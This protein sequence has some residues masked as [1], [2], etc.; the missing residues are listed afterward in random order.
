MK[1]VGNKDNDEE[2]SDRGSEA[3]DV[4]GGGGDVGGGAAQA[5]N[6]R[7]DRDALSNVSLDDINQQN[8]EASSGGGGCPC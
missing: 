6:A 2:E 3:I 8:D 5:R 7:K 4:H 1:G